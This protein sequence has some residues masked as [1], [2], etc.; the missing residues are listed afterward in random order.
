MGIAQICICCIPTFRAYSAHRAL[1][2]QLFQRSGTVVHSVGQARHC[3]RQ[4]REERADGNEAGQQAD[5]AVKQGET[6]GVR[7]GEA[8][9]AGE[10]TGEGAQEVRAQPPEE[11]GL[12]GRRRMRASPSEGQVQGLRVRQQL[13]A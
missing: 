13:P 12:R 11:Q 4:C 6:G 2:K 8:E 3:E 1:V 9:A 7:K 10:R 5:D